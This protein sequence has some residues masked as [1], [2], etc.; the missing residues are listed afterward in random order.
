MWTWAASDRHVGFIRRRQAHE[1]LIHRI[2]A[3]LTADRVSAVDPELATDGISEVLQF[4]YRAPAWSTH[5]HC[6]TGRINT[7]D[8]DASWLVG[9]GRWSGTSPTT[10][11]TYTDEWSLETVDSGEPDFEISGT[12]RDLDA[13]MWNRPSLEPITRSGDTSEIDDL[14]ATGV[15]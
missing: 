8:T 14:I 12:A 3:E 2:D 7:S 5:E 1:A 15:Q 9:I 13:W 4:M 11:T 6:V 10:G